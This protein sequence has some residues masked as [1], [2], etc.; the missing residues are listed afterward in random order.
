MPPTDKAM[1]DVDK[2]LKALDKAV[3]A[4]RDYF[5]KSMSGMLKQPLESVTKYAKNEAVQQARDAMEYTNVKVKQL[6]DDIAKLDARIKALENA[7]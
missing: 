6:M 1:K 3:K 5:V 2:R 4:N 7:R